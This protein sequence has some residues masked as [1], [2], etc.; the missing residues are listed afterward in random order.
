MKVIIRKTGGFAGF[1]DLKE[2]DT[3]HMDS[4]A[5][6]EIE[7]TVKNMG[8][9]D[10]PAFG[11]SD[12][13]GA[14]LVHYEVTTIDGERRHTVAF[15]YDVSNKSAPLNKLVDTLNKY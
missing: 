15:N 3:A 12:T 7:S 14:D 11:S 13:V 9:F 8:F 4:D 2:I 10:L 5:A 6:D 1:D